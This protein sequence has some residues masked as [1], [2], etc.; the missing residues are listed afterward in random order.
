MFFFMKQKKL[1]K[2]FSPEILFSGEWVD[3][4]E[5]GCYRFL[6]DATDLSWVEAGQ[7]CQEIGGYLVELL[8]PR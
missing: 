7:K 6:N 8:T 2:C 5:L 3:A 1:F 4:G